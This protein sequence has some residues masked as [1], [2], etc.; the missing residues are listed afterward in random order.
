[1][2]DSLVGLMPFSSA[3]TNV[4]SPKTLSQSPNYYLSLPQHCFVKLNIIR[5]TAS[6]LSYRQRNLST[7]LLGTATL[8]TNPLSVLILTINSHLLTIVYLTCS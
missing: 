2:L 6:T 5:L 4:V 3:P 1:M 7:T 8:T